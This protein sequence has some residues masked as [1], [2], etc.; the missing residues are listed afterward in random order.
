[1]T[2][3]TLE[4]LAPPPREP[5]KLAGR[6]IKIALAVVLIIAI[7]ITLSLWKTTATINNYRDQVAEEEKRIRAEGYPINREELT[8]YVDP[9]SV[10]G[11]GAKYFQKAGDIVQEF[12]EDGEVA[13]AI[14]R[15]M[16]NVP[17]NEPL[18]DD[19]L[20][21]L[22]SYALVNTNAL[23]LIDLIPE[24]QPIRYD[25][26]PE[27]EGRGLERSYTLERA[28]NLLVLAATFDS[29]E[30]RFPSAIKRLAQSIRLAES[31]EQDFSI[32]SHWI[33]GEMIS[34]SNQCLSR[35][36]SQNNLDHDTLSQLAAIFEQ[37]PTKI[38][39]WKSMAA[40]R[41]FTISMFDWAASEGIDQQNAEWSERYGVRVYTPKFLA[42]AMMTVE[43]RCVLTGYRELFNRQDSSWANINAART[44]MLA[45]A[46]ESWGL[47]GP[48]FI[49]RSAYAVGHN[50]RSVTDYRLA[51]TAL[52]IERFRLDT[53]KA[54]NTLS[55]LVPNYLDHVPNDP[56][57]E[58]KIRYKNDDN[59]Y[60]IYSI[61][62]DQQD[63]DGGP[64]YM[65]EN[66]NVRG[67]WTLE[68]NYK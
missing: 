12:D 52:A 21:S 33:R 11:I 34:R 40:G 43:K 31:L 27:F 44:D 57:A 67:D 8:N 6:L 58:G 14:H 22:E 60:I 42:K 50:V 54:P 59:G 55:D 51:R 7:L 25:T 45:F 4:N 3:E 28:H 61:F 23:E 63:D 37:E 65:D 19:V 29:E 62:A 41:A 10:L 9:P 2:N 47:L 64:Y 5:S 26:T 36:L 13:D 35:M 46:D 49:T 66:D 39:F 38:T 16:V 18:P 24:D 30:G 20:V 32:P 53:G 15:N 17:G 1:M 48:N 68:V 56:Y